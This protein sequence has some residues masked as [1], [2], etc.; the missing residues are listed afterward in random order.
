MSKNYMYKSYSVTVSTEDCVEGPFQEWITSFL[1]KQEYAYGVIEL[2]K[3]GVRHAHFQCWWNEAK[4]KGTFTR[5]LSRNIAKYSPTSIMCKALK[6]NI[7]YSD[8]YVNYMEKDIVDILIDNVP[9]GDT[10]RFYPSEEEQQQAQETANAKDKRFHL[11][12][13]AFQEWW[14]KD[15]EEDLPSISEV[16]EFFADS[17]FSSKTMS[18]TTDKRIRIQNTKSLYMYLCSKVDV[19]E[20]L[21]DEDYFYWYKSKYNK[22]PSGPQYTKFVNNI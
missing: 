5:T 15:L 13:I 7:S 4:N 6:V 16:A 14:S 11:W 19:K 17:M 22:F 12:S 1:K 10:D 9:A 18:V 3:S 2:K 20:F 8:G 21:S